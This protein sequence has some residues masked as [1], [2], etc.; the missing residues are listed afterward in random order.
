MSIKYRLYGGFGLLV[1]MSLGLVMFAVHE[2][3]E[4]AFSVSRMNGI[5]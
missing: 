3:N 4:V 1:A 2:F 5:S